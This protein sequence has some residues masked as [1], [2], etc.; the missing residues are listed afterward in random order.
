MKKIIPILLLSFFIVSCVDSDTYEKEYKDRRKKQYENLNYQ[1]T[2]SSEYPK[3]VYIND[4]ID[5]IYV[6]SDSCEYVSHY[7]GTG[8]YSSE[9]QYFH[10]SQCK[11]CST[12]LDRKLNS[13]I[14]K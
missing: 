6:G 11:H 12:V 5:Y 14:K 3:K 1:P 8:G 9:N 4:H 2:N 7:I 10:Y 13:L